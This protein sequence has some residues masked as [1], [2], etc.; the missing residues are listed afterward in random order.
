[1]S[2]VA[3]NKS[4]EIAIPQ[5]FRDDWKRV[6]EPEEIAESIRRIT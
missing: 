1:M 2:V 4:I 5:I 3:C 6:F